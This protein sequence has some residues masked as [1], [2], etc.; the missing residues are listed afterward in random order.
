MQRHL[1]IHK[2]DGGAGGGGQQWLHAA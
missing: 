2:S 1:N